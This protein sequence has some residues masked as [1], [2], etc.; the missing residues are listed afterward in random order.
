MTLSWDEFDILKSE[1]LYFLLLI[2]SDSNIIAH[3][4]IFQFHFHF[5]VATSGD[6]GD[7]VA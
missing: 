1:E 3:L 4:K 7:I 6:I 2:L 5:N